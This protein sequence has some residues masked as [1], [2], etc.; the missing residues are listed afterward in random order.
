[1]GNQYNYKLVVVKVSGGNNYKLPHMGKDRLH[2]DGNLP[3]TLQCDLEIVKE[4]LDWLQQC[5]WSFCK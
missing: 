3:Y 2:K 4:V 1:M 5:M